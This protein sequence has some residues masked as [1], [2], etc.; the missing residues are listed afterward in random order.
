MNWET[1]WRDVGTILNTQKQ[2]YS[3][4]LTNFGPGNLS[5]EGS[6]TASKSVG[7]ISSVVQVK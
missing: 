1:H 3:L 6:V 2:G 4:F 7:G 5:Y